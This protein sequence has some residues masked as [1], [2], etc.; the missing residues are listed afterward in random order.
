MSYPSINIFPSSQ[1][2]NLVKSLVNVLLPLP[3]CPT[4]PINSPALISK[5]IFFKIG[6]VHLLKEKFTF[7]ITTEPFIGGNG[8]LVLSKLD[9]SCGVLTTSANLSKLIFN[10]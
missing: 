5:L 6:V 1:E 10:S 7:F 2:Y 9:D 4:I 3:L 8:I